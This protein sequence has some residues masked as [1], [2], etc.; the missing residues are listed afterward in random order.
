MDTRPLFKIVGVGGSACIAID[1]MYGHGIEKATFAIVDTSRYIIGNA[2][3]PAKLLI[4]SDNRAVVRPDRAKAFASQYVAE[5]GSLFDDG[6]QMAFIIAGMGGITG[7]G[8]APT[9]ARIARE[10]NIL[11]IGIVTM[12][13]KAEGEA[14]RELARK[15]VEE[16]SAHVD[17][18]IVIDDEQLYP[19]LSE[20]SVL[21]SISKF[22]ETVTRIINDIL[23]ICTVQALTCIDF[24][25]IR[26]T[27]QKGGNTLVTSA[28]SD[29]D[30]RV[31][32]AIKKAISAPI[33]AGRDVHDASRLLI[34]IYSPADDKEALKM[35]EIEILANYLAT[36]PVDTDIIW[37]MAVDGSL[38]HEVRVTII[39]TGLPQ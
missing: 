28:F 2:Q 15:G 16:M 8:A 14:K 34:M 33:C 10:R 6:T 5:I 26:F 25:D 22:D 23:G 12:P 1:R 7:T 9:V 21:E 4:S 17:A 18:M 3:V 11:T 32:S 27:F 37:G 24:N 36:F 39:A 35:K 19:G 13:F 20:E 31:I 29:G 30:D 38:K